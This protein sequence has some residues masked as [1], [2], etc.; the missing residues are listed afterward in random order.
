MT[1]DYDKAI[2]DLESD[3][4]K[5][6]QTVATFNDRQTFVILDEQWG[7]VAS[8]P[9]PY[10]EQMLRSRL[11]MMSSELGLLKLKREIYEQD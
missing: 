8:L 6:K 7:L 5:L 11:R 1:T 3:V 10:I 2:T 4:A 9:G